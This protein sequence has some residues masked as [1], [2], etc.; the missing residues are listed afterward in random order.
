MA[1]SQPECTVALAGC[2]VVGGALVRLLRG[3]REVDG[4]PIAIT[5]VLVKRPREVRPVYPH[6]VTLDLEEFLATRA[7]VVVE[8]IGG[9]EPALTIA[10]RVLGRGGRLVTA[11][12]ALIAVHG[13]ELATLAHESGGWL[14]FDAAVGGGV[15]VVRTLRDSLRGLPVRS[16]HGILNGTAN[17]VLTR[18]ESGVSLEAALAEARARGLAEADTSR[19]L[20][21]RDVAD[22][23]AILA[24][25]AW[26]VEPDTVQVDRVGLLPD[27]AGLVHGALLAGGRLRLVGRC[28][29][30]GGTVRARVRP[31]VVPTDSM[32]GGTLHEQNR[33]EIILGWTGPLTLTG[34]GAGGAPTATALWGDIRSAARAA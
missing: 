13:T 30:A 5:R 22:K 28:S 2:G 4:R 9:I 10:R 7:D 25:V 29:L 18:L 34:P 21:G 14:G 15:P 1:L 3:V 16:M 27:P 31:E 20:D 11:N 19:D 24:W 8:T 12:K 17:Y 33:V 26:G 23:L 32:L 6:S